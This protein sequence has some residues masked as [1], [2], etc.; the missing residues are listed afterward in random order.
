M[1]PYKDGKVC[2]N[3]KGDEVMYLFYMAGEGEKMPSSATM[4]GLTLPAGSRVSVLGSGTK[5]SWQN[6]RDSFTV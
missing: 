1:A 4:R 3:S 2:I 5:C 6:G